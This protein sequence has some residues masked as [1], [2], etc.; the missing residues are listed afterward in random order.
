[1]YS[2]LN[3]LIGN[4]LELLKL[5]KDSLLKA[6][7]LLNVLTLTYNNSKYVKLIINCKAFN[8]NIRSYNK[9]II[10]KH[11]CMHVELRL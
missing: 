7:E 8:D 4:A 5:T 1:M 2:A 6:Q 11:D 3:V 9:I 10:D